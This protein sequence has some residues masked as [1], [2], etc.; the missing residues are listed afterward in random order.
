MT[1]NDTICAIS[2]PAGCGGIAVV[3]VSGPQAVEAVGQ[4]WRGKDLATT[5]ARRATLGD[6]VDRQSGE[7]VDTALA[8]VM[9][10]PGS[11]TG[12]D[13]VELSV[14][15]S[16]WIQRE[17][18]RLLIDAG[19]RL[20]QPGEFTRRAFANGK[21][22]LAEAEAVADVIAS[23]TRESHRIAAQQ[24]RGD[25]SRRLGEL[26]AQL[27]D[28]S[29][30][31]ELELDFSEEDV[32]FAS[33]ERLL[34]IAGNVKNEVDRLAASFSMGKAIKEGVPVAIVG[35]P[36]AG[37]STLIN[38]LLEEDRAIVSDI[39]GT[40]RDTIEDTMQIGGVEFRLIDTAGIRTTDDAIE[41]LGI[42][43]SVKA[44]RRARITIAVVDTTAPLDQTIAIMR[45]IEQ[46]RAADTAVIAALNKSDAAGAGGRR[47]TD[48]A[49]AANRRGEDS[50]SQMLARAD[51]AGE[52]QP[53]PETPGEIADGQIR[54]SAPAFVTTE[55]G[56]GVCAI[57]AHRQAV[58][59][60]APEAAA[61]E[62]SALR[63]TGIDH[64]RQRLLNLTDL[65]ATND[66]VVSNARHY[67]A[68][69]QAS[70]SIDR[71]IAGLTADLAGVLIA[72]DLRQTLH[73]L[74]EITGQITTPEI[75][76][77]IFSRFCVG[78]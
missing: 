30:L 45:R 63:G 10:A 42:E 69:V 48:D 27:V 29:A 76:S 55:A 73:H 72:E 22:D 12:E 46:E 68:L 61:V 40:T 70:A 34:E 7:T 77:T 1:E 23:T 64:L 56:N 58:A 44:L 75:L 62:I 60:I 51:G 71:V 9:R 52:M 18:L 16:T 21:M 6:I 8:M 14:H 43:R 5:A 11:F 78:K 20:A 57:D 38:A 26:R 3:R 36:N 66:I 28:L 35:N 31:L 54:H 67:E 13:T 2:T 50:E 25:I 53:S 59:D 74:G 33:R 65:P 15:G 32:E 19:C 4:I 37:K 24:M 17:T 47:A 41:A 49:G 39:P